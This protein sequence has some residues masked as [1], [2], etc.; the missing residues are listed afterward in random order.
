MHRMHE[1]L[2]EEQG[3]SVG[4]STLTR[5]LRRL[6][7]A[8]GSQ[9]DP[10]EHVPDVA[11]QEMQH[12]TTV[13]RIALGDCVPVKLVCSGLYLRYSKMRYVKFYR[14]FNRYRMKCFIDDALRFWGYCARDCIIDNTSLAIHA[15]T[16][17]DAL[18][19]P[20]MVAFANNY[21]FRWVAHALGHANRKAGKERNFWT[22][23]TSF[24]P[25][26]TFASLEDLNAQAFQW[27]TVRYARRPQS[28]TGLIPI[29]LFEHEKPFLRTLPDF[30]APPALAHRRTLD[31]YGYIRFDT[32]FFW[33]PHTPRSEVA[34]VQYADHIVVYA[35]SHKELIRYPLPPDGTQKQVFNPPDK[36][37]TRRQPRN[38]KK[39]C[40]EEEQLLRQ[41]GGDIVVYLDFIKSSRCG[42]RY[43]RQFVRDL[44]ELSRT[45]DETV[46]VS[47]MRRALHY[48]VQSIKTLLRMAVQLTTPAKVPASDLSL[49]VPQ[50]DYQARPAFRE[51]QFSRENNP[52]I[53]LD[54][55]LSSQ[56][57][58]YGSTTP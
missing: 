8:K 50:R 29:Q 31:A 23:E 47:L 40:G 7:I 53:V 41:R 1:I 2:S 39:D 27:A 6:G 15:G 24:L 21:G 26:R 54:N 35:A 32:N 18:F 30:I 34:I 16:G 56:G 3:C 19:A 5:A 17:S 36:P 13:Y 48:R 42:V 28:H 9:P 25:G 49:P 51:G 45:I 43:K 57:D 37:G 58:S 22:V 12:D 33:V 11:G 55:Q 44:L 14:S 20:E 4:Y 10:A 52:Y 38:L 46:F